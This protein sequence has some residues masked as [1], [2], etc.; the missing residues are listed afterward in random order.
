MLILLMCM[1]FFVFIAMSCRSKFAHT[2]LIYFL[3]LMV[4]VFSGIMYFTVFTAYKPSDTIDYR[5]FLIL[6]SLRL[7]INDIS[8]MHNIGVSIVMLATVSCIQIVYPCKMWRRVMLYIPILVYFCT[9]LPSYDWNLFLM[10]ETKVDDGIVAMEVLQKIGNVF[11]L[12]YFVLPVVVFG[13]YSYRTK[14]FLKK[15]YGISCMSCILLIYII[16]FLLLTNG[17]FSPVMFYHVDLMNFPQ[18]DIGMYDEKGSVLFIVACICF[19][20]MCILLYFKPFGKQHGKR[21]FEQRSQIIN[22][23]MYLVMHSYKNTFLGIKKLV[24]LGI[25][26]ENSGGTAE[27]L[28]VLEKI[29]NEADLSFKDITRILSMLN[30]VSV[31]YRIFAIEGC[32]ENALKNIASDTVEIEKYYKEKRTLVLGSQKHMTECLLNILNNSVEA[33]EEKREL[34]G[35]IGITVH[36]E[37]DMLCVAMKDNGCGI[38]KKDSK[39]IFRPFYTTKRKGVGCGLGLDYVKSIALIHGGDVC[40]KSIRGVGTTV[41]VALPIYK[42]GG[43]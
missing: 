1:A 18:Q 22:S 14:I 8:I 33:I 10:L 34:N 40:I 43:N 32:I 13:L 16:T 4:I 7:S 30:D 21:Q 26:A 11:V 28:E 19:I 9:N 5:M 15:R 41:Y 20:N 39:K 17:A 23:N 2:I 27:V 31:D 6:L 36:V 24:K 25:D 42:K 35:K 12:L 29:D 38:P 3:G 37:S